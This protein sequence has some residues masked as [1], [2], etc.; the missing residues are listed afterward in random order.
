M[1]LRTSTA[2]GGPWAAS[3]AEIDHGAVAA[4]RQRQQSRRR[5]LDLAGARQRVRA[6]G[7]EKIYGVMHRVLDGQQ[8]QRRPLQRRPPHRPAYCTSGMADPSSGAVGGG[9]GLR[10]PAPV[11]AP[12]DRRSTPNSRS[13][14]RKPG[15]FAFPARVLSSGVLPVS[16]FLMRKLAPLSTNSLTSVD[17]GAGRRWRPAASALHGIQLTR[18]GAKFQKP[19]DRILGIALARAPSASSVCPLFIK[20][21]AHQC[22]AALLRHFVE[23]RRRRKWR[24]CCCTL[25]ITGLYT[26]RHL[27]S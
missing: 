23:S 8:I 21:A 13:C 9:G 25:F 7:E 14:S 3:A 12:E 10:Q 2:S 6:L 18:I 22:Y 27:G 15:S 11:P 16:F 4:C 1:K 26:T 24:A 5:R 17:I 20:A 19:R